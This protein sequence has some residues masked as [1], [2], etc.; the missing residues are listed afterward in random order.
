MT[1][2]A[3]GH[4]LPGVVL[5]GGRSAR[6]GV[7]K[8][9]IIFEGMTLLDRALARL[10][11]RVRS[12]ARR[13]RRPSA[14]DHGP[15]PRPRRRGRSGTARRARRGAARL[16]APD[17]RGRRG[18]PSVD[19]SDAH[20]DARGQDR[21][22]RRCGMRDQAGYR[23]APCGLLDGDPRCCRERPR[24]K[25]QIAAAADRRRRM[26]CGLPRA[27]GAAPASRTASPATSTRPRTSL[28]VSQQ[29]PR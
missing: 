19:R 14:D 4:P 23:A 10:D 28:E 26:R 16:T 27:N 20:Q 7:D 1:G 17:A 12:R 5:C 13:R 22:P 15:A 29:P 6:M 21:R 9:T 2:H 8:A 18:R 25:G 3:R 24:R 11:C